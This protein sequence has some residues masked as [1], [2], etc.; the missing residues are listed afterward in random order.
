VLP[1]WPKIDEVEGKL[2]GA[3]Q[4]RAGCDPETRKRISRLRL[5]RLS[6]GLALRG[7]VIS[8]LTPELFSV[9]YFR[10]SEKPLT[11]SLLAVAGMFNRALSGT[12]VK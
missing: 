11:K 7:L 8:F 10:R 4:M 2:V 12:T 1:K 3:W 9:E 5:N 6:S